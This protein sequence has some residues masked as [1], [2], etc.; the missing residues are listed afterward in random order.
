MKGGDEHTT[1]L[2]SGLDHA[3]LTQR[4][5]ELSKATEKS[6]EEV[7]ATLDQIFEQASSKIDKEPKKR[8]RDEMLSLLKA[9]KG[10]SNDST[11]DGK[12]SIIS[13]EGLE[14]AKA[15]GRFVSI[16]KPSKKGKEKEVQG[17]ELKK[18][19]KKKVKIESTADTTI[20]DIPTTTSTTAS[21]KVEEKPILP[22]EDDF[23]DDIFGGVEDYKGLGS[24]SDSDDDTKD[25]KPKIES[26]TS[27]IPSTAA[28]ASYFDEDDEE[29]MWKLNKSTAP[30]SVTNLQSK[31]SSNKRNGG[32]ALEDGEEVDDG[33]TS[34]K[35]QPL[36]G[37]SL[38]SVR[39]L[40]AM[41]ESA[42]R[43]EK[44]KAVSFFCC[45]Y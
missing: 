11:T 27:S 23:D 35:L 4:K 33:N 21:I 31:V 28:K 26:T 30:S 24:D 25:Q 6:A 1:V 32:D 39:D 17:G 3:L 5:Y 29:E 8:S 16:G 20:L 38:P 12:N 19:R 18:R 37:S 13:D 22:I 14:K 34:M 40:L 10:I 7:E 45:S 44:R 41:D 43:E 9:S 42:E 15:A 36:A 2:V